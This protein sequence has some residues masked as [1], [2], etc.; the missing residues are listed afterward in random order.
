MSTWPNFFIVGV[1]KCGTTSLYNYLK[2]IP[3][4][5]MSSDKEPLYFCP[6]L[7]DLGIR[8]KKR[9][10][11]EKDYLDLFKD[12]KNEKAIGEASAVYWRDPE[13]P[14]L[15][16]EKIPNAKIIISL[17][18]P[19]DRFFSG[20]LMEIHDL[21]HKRNFHE[22]AQLM[23]KMKFTSRSSK[24]DKEATLL[25][26]KNVKRYLDIFGKNQVLILIFEEWIKNP[27]IAIKKILNFLEIK[28]TTEGI[29][30][31]AYN[32]FQT[33][34]VPRGDLSHHFLHDE[35]VV[36]RLSKKMMPSSL[37]HYLSQKFLMKKQPKPKMYDEDK[38]EL[39]KLFYDDVKKL[40][41][42]IG[43]KLPWSNFN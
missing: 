10:D 35:T 20:Y 1:E 11:N 34:L 40:E 15:I 14:K 4:I 24:L 38:Q 13:A 16:H 19:V 32:A 42:I 31:I 30:T 3:E 5:Y 23:I 17:R 7:W 26:S 8:K 2:S 22:Y 21:D 9:I 18:N 12:V 36:S 33:K 27:R 41:I 25:Y 39:I 6:V 43:R 29:D 37:R 28:S